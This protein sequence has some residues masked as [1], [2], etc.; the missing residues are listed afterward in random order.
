MRLLLGLAAVLAL[1]GCGSVAGRSG[2]PA[3]PSAPPV[4]GTQTSTA[5]S[6]VDLMFTWGGGSPSTTTATVPTA[7]QMATIR[8]QFEAQRA[9]LRPAAGSPPRVVARLPLADGGDAVLVAWHNEEGVLCTDTEVADRQGSGGGGPGS[10]CVPAELAASPLLHC[11]QI[12]LTS[13]GSGA[14]M[15]HERWVLSGTVAA[16]GDAL[17][18]TTADGATAEYPLTGPLLDGGDRRVFMLELGK[19]DWRKLVLLHAGE[20]VDQTVL[21]ATSA[22]GEDCMAK[23]GE[24]PAPP[25]AQ[26]PGPI[27]S[28][29][30]MDAWNAS[31]QACVT[32]SGALPAFPAAT[33]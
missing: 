14:D 18:V 5:M 13:N 21:P 24:P 20:V 1:G 19:T 10:S 31:L 29:P 7:A 16:A 4:L 11:A 6:G 12:C 8:A 27:A 32:A 15:A 23:V 33:P 3:A 17:D 22:A 25:P 2:A 30:A 26:A 9:A 28:T